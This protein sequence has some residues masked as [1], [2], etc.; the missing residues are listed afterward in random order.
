ML[1]LLM[2]MMND[3][4]ITINNPSQNKGNGLLNRIA[5]VK[6]LLN[7]KQCKKRLTWATEKK[8]YWTVGQ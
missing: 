2:M 5:R 1:L 3:D 4:C 7:F 6:P 8:R